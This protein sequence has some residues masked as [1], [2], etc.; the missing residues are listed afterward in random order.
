L[1]DGQAEV[2]GRPTGQRRIDGVR[3][4]RQPEREQRDHRQRER[5][6]HRDALPVHATPAAG[7]REPAGFGATRL[8]GQIPKSAPIVIMKPPTQ[9]Q[10]TSG[11]TMTESVA[12]EP[13]CSLKASSV[14]YRSLSGRVRTAG[15]AT[16]SALI[17]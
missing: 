16:G 10:P 7:C 12:V 5:E 13:S 14:R 4:T 15:V 2:G 11:S 6:T 3:I 1:E 8:R 17:A 9:I